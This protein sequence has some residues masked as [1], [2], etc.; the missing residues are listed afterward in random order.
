MKYESLLELVKPYLK[1]N[2]LGVEHTLRV[3]EIAKENYNKYDLDES[4]KDIVF[5]LILLHDV[6]GSSI[7]EQYFNGP[8]IAKKLLQQLGY[9]EFDIKLICGC[10]ASHHEIL[11]NP[12]E[13]FKILFDSDQLVK[14]SKEEF[15]HYSLQKDF[16]WSKVIDSLYSAD[17]KQMAKK[18]LEEMRKGYSG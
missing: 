3:L 2:E 15:G 11:K 9:H 6:G 13:I 8:V 18:R 7:K 5:S 10:I 4:W 14:L 17:L 16:D 1:N 12:H